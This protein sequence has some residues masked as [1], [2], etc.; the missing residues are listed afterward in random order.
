MAPVRNAPARSADLSAPCGRHFHFRD[1]IEC[2]ETWVRLTA[3]RGIPFDNVP[4]SEETFEAIRALCRIVLDPLVDA[5]GPVQ[6]TYGFASSAL[7]KHIQSRIAPHLDQH[8]G[9]ERT[10]RG[11]LICSRLGMAADCWSENVGGL[12]LALWIANHT[13]FDRLYFYGDDSPVHVSVGPDASR[14]IVLVQ[15]TKA[16]RVV[17]RVVSQLDLEHHLRST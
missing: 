12:R 7:T 9:H 15:R 14:Q 5:L 8:A 10:S 1:L 6:L 2:G 13:G 17:P 3:E 11:R 16:G 4:R